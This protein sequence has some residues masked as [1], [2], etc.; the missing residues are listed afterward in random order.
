[1]PKD[2]EAQF[3]DLLRSI[4]ALFSGVASVA[5]AGMDY[6]AH[7]TRESIHDDLERK[8]I[9]RLG[10]HYDTDEL[11]ARN[12]ALARAAGFPD[13]EGFMEAFYERL[14][15]V[16]AERDIPE[17]VYSAR[18]AAMTAV[19]RL[20]EA[21]GLGSPLPKPLT[22]DTIELARYRDRLLARMHK[23]AHPETLS[24]INLTLADVVEAYIK[25]L[26]PLAIDTSEGDESEDPGGP[27]VPLADVLPNLG[28]AVYQVILPFYR[29]DVIKLGLFSDLRTQIEANQAEAAKHSKAKDLDPESYDGD[30]V[31]DAFLMGTPLRDLFRISVPFALPSE[32]RFSGHWIIAPPGRGKTNLLH[33]MVLDDLKQNSS[34]VLMD[35]K[36]DLIEPLKKLAAV[37]DRLVLIEPD[38]D[39][40][41]ALNPL[42]IP[43][44]NVAHT[45][46]L[47][48]YVFSALLEAKMT[49]LQ[50]TL[51]RSVL[52][53]LVQVI[54][55]P[56]L[57][58]FREIITS[59]VGQYEQ[60]IRKLPTSQQEF[61]FDKE[62][63]FLSRTYTDTRNQLIW[64]LQFLMTNP[65]IRQMFGAMKTKFDIA[66]EMDAGKI[67]L[68]NNSKAVLGDE[69]SEFFGRFFI[70]L[71]LAAAQQRAGRRSD[72]KLPC[73]VYIDECH[74]VI[75]RDEK[76]P[77]IL[78]ECRSQKIGLILA[79]Q[80]TAQLDAKV[81]DA[82]ANCAIRFAN[83]DDEAKFLADKLRTTSEFL[84]SLPRGTFA[85]FVRDLTPQALALK[86]PYVD[87]SRLPK[88]TEREQL[89]IRLRMREQFS[90]S[91]GA[92]DASPE[93][94]PSTSGAS[95]PKAASPVQ[96]QSRTRDA[97]DLSEADQKE[98]GREW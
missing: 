15:T 17:P 77:T 61:F 31:V 73:F 87:V 32:Q 26:P 54:P 59:G 42:D 57:E 30:D 94:S 13:L 84:R 79:H 95:S 78:D 97:G 64:R 56:T 85:A 62:T 70:A 16:A 75:R 35:S 12:A 6:A 80:R 22:D 20:Y 38:P 89:A 82:V 3:F 76:I 53:A 45:V 65:I 48:E 39:F 74:N 93:D 68:I 18:A 28:T 23:T 40:P 92:N 55:N 46:S 36:G 24:L 60:Y 86:I 52:P 71:I 43:K 29:S 37:K 63:G 91:P 69:G 90:F 49:A 19:G 58:T 25:T 51:F 96:S 4:G 47:L 8:G 10:A 72:Q 66:R 11:F 21:E 67:I 7:K 1:M 98:A 44:T 88:M 34:I 5:G 83:S 50:Q 33:A 9:R 81:L 41:L 2:T 27:S 14:G